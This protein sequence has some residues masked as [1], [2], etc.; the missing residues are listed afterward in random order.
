MN[1][2][3]FEADGACG[4]CTDFHRSAGADYCAVHARLHGC[5]QQLCYLPVWSAHSCALHVE[6][7]LGQK[8]VEVHIAYSGGQEYCYHPLECHQGLCEQECGAVRETAAHIGKS[9]QR[10]CVEDSSQLEKD[11]MKLEHAPTTAQARC[12]W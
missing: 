6:F 12:A 1:L 2:A 4:E 7:W 8:R 10:S 5:S 3:A 11:L 9:G